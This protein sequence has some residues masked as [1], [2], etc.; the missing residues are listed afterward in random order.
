M[1]L[2]DAV[3]RNSVWRPQKEWENCSIGTSWRYS[4]HSDTPKGRT[5]TSC[6]LKIYDMPR[7]VI[8]FSLSTVEREPRCR[9]HL[10]PAV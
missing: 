1:F 8:C 5:E 6:G 4:L 7:I 3:A 10:Y 9:E 2:T